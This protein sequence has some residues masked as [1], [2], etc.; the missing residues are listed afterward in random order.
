MLARPGCT[1]SRKATTDAARGAWPEPWVGLPAEHGRDTCLRVSA[2]DVPTWWGCPWMA[3]GWVD[4]CAFMPVYAHWLGLALVALVMAVVWGAAG[5]RGVRG[6]PDHGWLAWR[7]RPPGLTTG[8]LGQTG[9]N[10]TTDR[11]DTRGTI[12]RNGALHFDPSWYPSWPTWGAY[13]LT[14]SQYEKRKEKE[15]RRPS[16]MNRRTRLGRRA[17]NRRALTQA[18]P[19]CSRAHSSPYALTVQCQ[20]YTP[21]SRDDSRESTAG[22]RRNT[23]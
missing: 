16:R 10:T 23:S 6:W 22:I 5:A 12:P 2:R 15:R 11:E 8:R 9:T 17:P 7:G 3:A 4:E 14:P 21:R 20:M 13:E 18:G 1:G 19:N